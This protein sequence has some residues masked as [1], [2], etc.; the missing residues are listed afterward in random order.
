[1]LVAVHSAELLEVWVFGD[2]QSPRLSPGE[3]PIQ[4]IEASQLAAAQRGNVQKLKARLVAFDN[5]M[6]RL[7]TARRTAQGTTRS[8][9]N[10]AAFAETM[11]HRLLADFT[12][13]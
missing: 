4:R 5:E 13:S 7:A 12:A 6:V 2:F 1:M 8:T 3:H 9:P 10:G 11:A